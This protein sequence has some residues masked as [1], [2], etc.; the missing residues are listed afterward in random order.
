MDTEKNKSETKTEGITTGNSETDEPGKPKATQSK[1][2]EF[3]RRRAIEEISALQ[4]TE[5]VLAMV[6]RGLMRPVAVDYDSTEAK[7]C[8]QEFIRLSSEVTIEELT[9]VEFKLWQEVQ[10]WRSVLANRDSRIDVGDLRRYCETSKPPLSPQALL[11]LARF[12]RSLSF[13]PDV[14]AKYDMLITRLFAY[15]DEGGDR[16]VLQDRQTI[17]D[18]LYE[19]YREWL[20]IVPHLDVDQSQV[21]EAVKQFNDFIAESEVAHNVDVLVQGKFFERIRNYKGKLGQLFYAPAVTAAVIECN[22]KVGNRFI[23]LF[24][25]QKSQQTVENWRA[26]VG[27]NLLLEQVA[28]EATSKTLSLIAEGNSGRQAQAE[29]TEPQ[30]I[31]FG[32]VKNTSRP[33]IR[34]QQK[35]KFAANK[36]VIAAG[37]LGIASSVGIYFWSEYSNP[38]ISSANVRKLEHEQ[39]PGGKNLKAARVHDNTLFVIA[40][41]AWKDLSEADKKNGLAELLN[42]G[43]EKG[44][45]RVSLRNQDGKMVGQATENGVDLF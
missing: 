32:S 26:D 21:D 45:A 34:K 11:S 1:E 44:Y 31:H 25:K 42:A 5:Q 29:E 19:L 30:K 38:V 6:E 41:K 8:L 36:W 40:E 13:Q 39:L 4:M 12:Y 16:G 33:K 43:K 7:R 27:L 28:S 9:G 18:N 14:L 2:V 20:G 35:G 24:E 10:H 23:N 22:V 15:D 3:N 17:T 37:L